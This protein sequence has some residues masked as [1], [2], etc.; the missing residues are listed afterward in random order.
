MTPGPGTQVS[1]VA[2]APVLA[3]NWTFLSSRGSPKLEESLEG[4]RAAIE[5]SQADGGKGVYVVR[6]GWFWDDFAGGRGD[7]DQR[8][9]GGD[10][11]SSS[12]G[13]GRAQPAQTKPNDTGALK[14]PR[15]RAGPCPAPFQF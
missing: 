1:H 3:G 14:P 10:Q 5:P 2:T 13:V 4:P 7:P 8:G 11:F 12:C 6:G 15:G 9:L